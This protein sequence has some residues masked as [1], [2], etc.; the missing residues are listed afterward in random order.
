MREIKAPKGYTCYRTDE[1]ELYA[2]DETNMNLF[3]DEYY[4]HRE[5]G[6]PDEK[7]VEGYVMDFDEK[8]STF[9]FNPERK[10]MIKMCLLSPIGVWLK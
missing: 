7:E 5:D 9:N 6:I 3:R 10:V 1:D 8:T 4:R 2:L